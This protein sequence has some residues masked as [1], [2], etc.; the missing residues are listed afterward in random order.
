M[1]SLRPLLNDKDESVI[2][3]FELLQFPNFDDKKLAEA[4]SARYK[5]PYLDIGKLEISSNV[6]Q[7]MQKQQ[8]AK[9]RSIPV[10]EKDGVIMIA[11]YDPTILS[12]A[13][14]IQTIIKREIGFILTNLSAWKK[15]YET[16]VLSVDELVSTIKEVVFESDK[17]E[18]KDP[19]KLQE[20]VGEKIVSYVNNVLAAAFAKG[21]SDIHFEPY[22]K[23]FR[24][25]LRIDGDLIEYD[26]PSLKYLAPTISRVKIMSQMDISERRKPQD[27]RIKLI[28]GGRDIDY[29]VSAMPTL[30]GEKIV[31][32]S[33]S[34]THLT[35]PT[36]REV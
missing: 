15:A 2:T 28:M 13:G 3:D 19:Q 20:D 7:L 30:F 14:S 21:A 32:R 36:N 11:I 4:I 5:I 35:L 17:D 24:V 8:M 18:K 9:F 31:L 23:I 22:E 10:G 12:L 26:R 34:Y 27:G 1:Q 25:R 29:R 16:A 6:S 33:V